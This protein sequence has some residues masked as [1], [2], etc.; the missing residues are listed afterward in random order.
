MK[1]LVV[2]IEPVQQVAAEPGTL[3]QLTASLRAELAERLGSPVPTGQIGDVYG[4]P[5]VADP[6]L[7]PGLVYLRPHP[8][9]R[10]GPCPVCSHSPHHAPGQCQGGSVSTITGCRCA[11]GQP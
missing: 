7:P 10:D 8:R 4:W 5:L 6:G 3:D 2:T 1:F 11:G 9:P